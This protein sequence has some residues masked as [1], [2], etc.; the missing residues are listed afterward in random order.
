MRQRADL[1]TRCRSR[2]SVEA[3]QGAA[4]PTQEGESADS[5]TTSPPAVG[6]NAPAGIGQAIDTFLEEPGNEMDLKIPSRQP[7]PH[8]LKVP[9]ENLLRC[10]SGPSNASTVAGH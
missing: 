4:Y 2:I 8:S 6:P 9:G 10:L 3:F 1:S 5:S 7:Y